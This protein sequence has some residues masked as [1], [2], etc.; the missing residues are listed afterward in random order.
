MPDTNPLA[1]ATV[2][3]PWGSM[4]VVGDAAGISHIRFPH[5]SERHV[6]G[7]TNEVVLE[8]ATQ[9]RAYFA[10]TR[11]S[12]TLPLKPEGPEFQIAVWTATQ[13]IPFGETMTYGDLA[14]AIGRP[15]ACR[16]VGQA[17]GRN[18]I[19]IVIPCHRVLS[20][21][22]EGGFSG[23]LAMKRALLALESMGQD[24]TRGSLT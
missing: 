3:T 14:S 1:S 12:F 8:A 2:A 19:P 15:N 11:S 7:V 22:G 9:L 21:H 24:V 18:P 17:L 16:A 13:A 10:G 4:V 23:G 20:R 6:V 5:E